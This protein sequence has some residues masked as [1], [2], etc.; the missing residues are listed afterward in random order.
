MKGQ[1]IVIRPWCP[2][3]GQHVGKP[4]EP[5]QRKLGEFSVGRCECGAV[6]ASDPTGHNIDYYTRPKVFGYDRD[7]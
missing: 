6:Y 2:F 7:A 5:D 4:T 1:D 3:C